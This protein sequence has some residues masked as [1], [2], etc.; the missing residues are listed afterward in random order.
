MECAQKNPKLDRWR[1]KWGPPGPRTQLSHKVK[2]PAGTSEEPKET[3]DPAMDNTE[4]TDLEPWGSVS[5]QA[6][7]KLIY[8]IFRKKG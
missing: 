5:P 6:G 3:A 7:V 4:D 1:A 8:L 2:D